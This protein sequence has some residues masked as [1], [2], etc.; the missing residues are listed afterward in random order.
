MTHMAWPF[1][2]SGQRRKP[3][4][5]LGIDVGGRVTKA[6]HLQRR[7]KDIALCRYAVLDAPICEGAVPPEL[8]TEHL[9]S[10][11]QAL[12]ARTKVAAFALGIADSLVRHVQMPRM[13]LAD[14]RLVLKNN[15]RTYLQQDLPNHVFDVHV[16]YEAMPPDKPEANKAA[17]G[18]P[19]QR[20]LVAGAKKQIVDGLA[21]SAKAAGLEVDCIVPALICPLN[22]FELALPEVFNKEVVALV[23]IGFKSSSI[24]LLQEGELTLSRVV[25]LGGDKLTAGVAEALSISYAEAE[26]IKVGMP[27]EIQTK[28]EPLVALLGRE[29]R[30]LIDF[31][32]H[33]YDRPVRQVYMSGGTARSD[34]IL[35]ML[36]GELMVECQRWNPAGALQSAL[37]PQQVAEVEQVA[38][39]LA[40]AVGAALTAL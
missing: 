27:Q 16:I 35:Q 24:C 9:K 5:I 14:M 2:N 23:D 15:S 39:Q 34:L 25:N 20:L 38:P 28:L 4:Q 1:L 37:P 22:A 6:V 17:S 30:A 3:D 8:L 13:P 40:V 21:A 19:R 18:V 33:Q 12:E 7:G 31:Y 29:L 10:V 26:G 36:H 32:E 11:R